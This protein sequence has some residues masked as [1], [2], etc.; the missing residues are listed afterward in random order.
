MTD[1]HINSLF[2]IELSVLQHRVINPFDNSYKSQLAA[3]VN[4]LTI[5]NLQLQQS[6]QP[7]P[8][9]QTASEQ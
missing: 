8:L 6:Q 2:A 7:P 1:V 3:S 9:P 4:P 5:A